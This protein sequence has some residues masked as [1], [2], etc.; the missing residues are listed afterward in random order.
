[1]STIKVSVVDQVLTIADSPLIASGDVN[2]DHVQ[3]TF[4]DSWRGFGLAAVFYREGESQVYRSVIPRN[5]LAVIPHE[6][7]VSQGRICFGV[8]GVAGSDV[9]TTEI[10]Y[11]DIHEGA[12]NAGAETQ[13]PTPGIYEQMLSS[14]G[15]LQ[16]YF[17][18]TVD[19]IER[20]AGR[21]VLFSGLASS[22][23]VVETTAGSVRR[24]IFPNSKTI[25]DFDR[26]TLQFSNLGLYGLSSG[27]G[28]LDIHNGAI[29]IAQ[30]TA[31]VDGGYALVELA[32]LSG[33]PGD[34]AY[35][36]TVSNWYQSGG[37]GARQDTSTLQKG[38]AGYLTGISYLDLK[39]TSN[40]YVN[41]IGYNNELIAIPD[42]VDDDDEEG[43]ETLYV[44][45]T[46]SSH[47]DMTSV[48]IFNAL[49]TAQQAEQ[50]LHVILEDHTGRECLI[51][52]KPGSDSE[53]A[54]FFTLDYS[55]NTLIVYTVNT[56][57]SVSVS[58]GI[59]CH[60]MGF[61]Y[62]E[63][64]TAAATAAKTATI[65][66]FRLGASG[67]VIIKFTN[68]VP[69]NATLNISSTGAKPIYFA[70][71][72]ITAG[73]INAGATATM[74][75]A[76]STYIVLS[77]DDS[78]RKPAAGI[79]EADL[80]QAVQD[81]L[82]AAGS[83]Q[84]KFITVTYY[85]GDYYASA[86]PAQI[87]QDLDDG[88]VEYILIDRYGRQC[89]LVEPPELPTGSTAKF[90]AIDKAG[91]TIYIHTISTVN[92]LNLV[93]TSSVS[94]GSG[95]S[96]TWNDVKP[97][98]G[99][100]ESDLASAVRNKL[101]LQVTISWD[102]SDF[103]SNKTFAQVSAA[104]TAGQ[105]I[106]V[107]IDDMYGWFGYITNSTA[108]FY[109]IDKNS[110]GTPILYT[111]ELTSSGVSGTTKTLGDEIAPTKTTVSGSTPSIAAAANTI[112][113]CGELTS[114]TISSIP[115]TGEFTV[116]FESGSTATT[117]SLPA[118]LKMPANYSIDANTL[119][120]LNVLDGRGVIAG[121]STGS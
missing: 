21:V 99:I 42:E 113:T 60:G 112:Y 83:G 39:I 118:T 79:P 86:G 2:V 47:A 12:V 93:S 117:V 102:G 76:N 74:V 67:I 104:V 20:S 25:T 53:S 116:V 75:Y 8:A 7:M 114:L 103:S 77:V 38:A 27:T 89:A 108:T 23:P 70:G 98:G 100:P 22:L 66:N 78:Y 95:S 101:P 36:I 82:N 45:M 24:L 43:T 64:S 96:A 87:F 34:N 90:A 32:G 5:G 52:Y 14:V 4:D 72:A 120:E 15:D 69:A 54:R 56:S 10:A 17:D 63:C 121:W 61:G 9:K 35:R 92:T 110:G 84:T 109:A 6:V 59:Y 3:F 28:T 48:E 85:D 50:D 57:G 97:S 37:T 71:A 11:Y 30:L 119:Y 65:N 68:A 31:G 80:S 29:S 41:V 19:A 107:A 16:D 26:I 46:S 1:M 18:A 91:D 40:T 33:T 62:G 44:H 88:N 115:A 106:D 58:S 73:V 111:F 105:P 49:L 55:T 94:I 81:K 51:C 13:S